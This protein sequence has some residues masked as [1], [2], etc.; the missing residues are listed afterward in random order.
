MVKRSRREASI[1]HFK[2]MTNI[3]ETAKTTFE[4]ESFLRQATT[5]VVFTLAPFTVVAGFAA[6]SVTAV[7]AYSST[8]TCSTDFGGN[9]MCLT[10]W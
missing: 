3:N 1:T 8:A 5:G 2:L 4:N 10:T 9:L 6:I 7:A